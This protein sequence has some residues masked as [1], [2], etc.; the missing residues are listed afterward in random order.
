M[1]NSIYEKTS[2]IFR[3]EA[4]YEKYMTLVDDP[5]DYDKIPRRK[6]I[7]KCIEIFKEDP[8]IINHLFNEEELEVLYKLPE[9]VKTN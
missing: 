3:K 8:G 9:S 1:L 7:E 5:I 6:M 4:C 2:K